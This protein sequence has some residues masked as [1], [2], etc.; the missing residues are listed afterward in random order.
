MRRISLLGFALLLW[1]SLPARADTCFLTTYPMDFGPYDPMANAPLDIN[2]QVGVDCRPPPWANP[3]DEVVYTIT[4]DSGLH[5]SGT[6][7]PRK[8]QSGT[9]GGLMSYN[10]YIDSARTQVWGDGTESTYV[11]E[12]IGEGEKHEFVST[13]T[14]YGRIPAQQTSLTPGLYS[15]VITVTVMF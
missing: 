8:M 13:L 4:L 1:L 3:A 11:I 7:F 9:D 12:G 5:S 6:F 15:D 10:L 14:I 2:G